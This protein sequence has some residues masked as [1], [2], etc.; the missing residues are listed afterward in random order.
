MGALGKEHL[1]PE[2]TCVSFLSVD[3]YLAFHYVRQDQYIYKVY[4][5]KVMLVF[6]QV[7]ELI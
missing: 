5:T 6:M 3:I 4:Q 7:I 1:I 2:S